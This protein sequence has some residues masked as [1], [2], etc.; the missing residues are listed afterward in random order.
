[1]MNGG[2]ELGDVVARQPTPIVR[3]ADK[4]FRRGVDALERNRF[5]EAAGL[6]RQAAELAPQS[7]AVHLALGI[8]LTRLTEIPAAF[9]A[10]ETAIALDPKGFFPHFRMGE[11]YLRVGVPTRGKEE[12]QLAMDLSAAPEQR[13]MVRELLA[14]DAKRAP[15]RAWRPDFSRIIGR[16]PKHS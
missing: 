9:A 7:S 1:M 11:L 4:L 2:I 10:L 12:L 5:D 13:S 14:F 6:L 3:D 8:A 15:K 16:K